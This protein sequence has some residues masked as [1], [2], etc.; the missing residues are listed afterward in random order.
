[1]HLL[2]W[3]TKHVLAKI[4]FK[5]LLSCNTLASPWLINAVTFINSCGSNNIFSQNPMHSLV[6]QRKVIRIVINQSLLR[7][8]NFSDLVF[9]NIL[10]SFHSMLQKLESFVGGVCLFV[11]SLLCSFCLFGCIELSEVHIW[12]FLF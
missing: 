3:L 11:E 12:K 9:F 4:R 6:H 2:P 1:M 8:R 7:F 10:V 5:V